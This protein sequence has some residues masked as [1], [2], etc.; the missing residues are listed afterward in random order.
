MSEEWRQRAACRGR[1]VAYW[2]YTGDE[3]VTALLF[4]KRC[5]VKAECLEAGL[6]EE[7][8]IWGGL[9]RDQRIP[10]RQGLTPPKGLTMC[11]T[12]GALFATYKHQRFCSYDCRVAGARIAAQITLDAWKEG[13][14]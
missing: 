8:G 3:A 14:A 5:P 6:W 1:D 13:A 7:H 11:P 4:C 10:H 12:C 2:F 9:T